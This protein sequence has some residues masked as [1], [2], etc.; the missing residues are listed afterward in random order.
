MES[1]AESK[2]V[3]E[4]QRAG[5]SRAESLDNASADR[6]NSSSQDSNAEGKS[7]H[8][9]FKSPGG[10]VLRSRHE[11]DVSGPENKAERSAE[12]E[13]SSERAQEANAGESESE[14]ESEGGKPRRVIIAEEIDNETYG[15]LHMITKYPCFIAGII[16]FLAG[17]CTVWIFV[18][19]QVE[20]GTT[21]VRDFLKQN[22]YTY[23]MYDSINLAR[24]EMWLRSSRMEPESFWTTHL[25][26]TI[27]KGD[28]VFTQ[29][30]IKVIRRIAAQIR[31][32]E[33]TEDFCLKD[34]AK[35]SGEDFRSRPCNDNEFMR[36]I[37][38][39]LGDD[40]EEKEIKDKL[41]DFQ[42]KPENRAYFHKTVS[43]ANV[44]S[45]I[46]R[47]IFYYG[48]QS[49]HVSSDDETRFKKYS[50]QVEEFVRSINDPELNFYLFS[51]ALYEEIYIDSVKDDCEYLS[52]CGIF[53]FCYL[54][55]R[56]KSFFLTICGFVQVLV[57][58][59]ISYMLYTPLFRSKYL[60]AIHIIVV[61]VG[62][63]VATE[64]L[65]IFMGHWRHS[66]R[67]RQYRK[68]MRTRLEYTMK[69]SLGAITSSTIVT[70]L[71]FCSA[72]FSKIVSISS[73]GYSM[74]LVTF[75]NYILLHTFFP[76]MLIFYW[77]YLRKPF[78]CV[79]CVR[80]LVNPRP[81]KYR[82][83]RL[84]TLANKGQ[85]ELSAES[86]ELPQSQIDEAPKFG[87]AEK[88][89]YKL[90]R[91]GIY[92]LAILGLAIFL[93][94]LITMI[95]FS[96]KV[97]RMTKPEQLLPSTYDITFARELVMD[98]FGYG[99]GTNNVVIHFVYGIRG[100]NRN[101]VEYYDQNNLGVVEWD[102][103]LSIKA[104]TTRSQLSAICYDLKNVRLGV[105]VES[106]TREV[107]TEQ[108]RVQ[109]LHDR[110]RGVGRSVHRT[111]LG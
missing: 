2:V 1:D 91:S 6:D 63:I 31:S 70:V 104:A 40:V 19:G 92:R 86:Q 48:T 28:T 44:Q 7:K 23:K 55:F 53:L 67:Y 3:S 30:N 66:K 29:E 4:K 59:P 108:Q 95:Y 18:T 110:L 47:I 87:V 84:V 10:D 64:N 103:S 83:A 96:T 106:G 11:R 50:L 14:R 80:R 20:F 36:S 74:G 52:Y 17:I 35:D 26:V 75:V 51:E 54:W 12:S 77:K 32:M 27:K 100:V 78:D 81:E 97:K 109:L 82:I 72:G 60:G 15:C 69:E 68:S 90:Y 102:E 46:T 43:A 16:V 9:P 93:G 25:V 58:L 65:I 71:V 79:D 5:S 88:L 61:Y 99:E 45:N 57:S 24:D 41:A 33:G 73:F 22:E 34:V 13:S 42:S 37:I 56:T 49:G 111:G 8:L 39:S 94:L 38:F 105:R 107:Q 62:C 76:S 21:D 98:Q 89:F 101:D 85:I